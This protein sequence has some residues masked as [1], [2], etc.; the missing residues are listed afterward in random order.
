MMPLASSGYKPGML[1]HPAMHR[2][3]PTIENYLAPNVS[4]AKAEEPWPRP[5]E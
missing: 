5:G 3:A 2:T 4:S 1:L